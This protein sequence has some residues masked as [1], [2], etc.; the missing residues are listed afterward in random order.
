M[1]NT[2][3]PKDLAQESDA[4]KFPTALVIIWNNGGE[5][6]KANISQVVNANILKDSTPIQ[7]STRLITS[8]G[9]WNFTYSKANLDGVFAII[10]SA[11]ANKS[12]VYTREQVNVLLNNKAN[13]ADVYVKTEVYSKTE[14]DSLANSFIAL[15]GGKENIATEDSFAD[16]TSITLADNTIYTASEPISALSLEAQASGTSVV[17]FDTASSGSITITTIGITFQ[18]QP[19]FGNNEHWEVAIRNGYA[20]YSKFDLV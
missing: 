4:T 17:S 16:N 11:K 5:L 6:K 15:L 2:I 8:G 7:G 12:E 18:S 9:V 1:A 14:I 13:V 20:V 10:N 19:E 3:A